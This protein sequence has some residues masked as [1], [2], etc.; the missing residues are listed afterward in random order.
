MTAL[1][2]YDCDPKK[3]DPKKLSFCL[4][5]ATNIK[6]RGYPKATPFPFLPG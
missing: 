5:I 2:P 6:K 1:T 4:P 3:L